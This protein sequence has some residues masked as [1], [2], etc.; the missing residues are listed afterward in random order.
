M[1]NWRTRLITDPRLI[2]CMVMVWV[3][4]MSATYVQAQCVFASP[5]C[6]SSMSNGTSSN[7]NA[8]TW[9][10]NS[11]P[12]CPTGASSSYGGNLKVSMANNTNLTISANF[13]VNGDFNIVNSG[14]NATLTI[15]VGVTLHV[16]GDLGDCTNNNVNFVVNG[17]LIVDGYV[18]GKNGNS[19]AGTGSIT[20][21]GGLYFQG[22]PTCSS[23]G[24]TW[25]V[26]SCVP[27]GAFCTLP[28]QLTSF[29]AAVNA[30]G[31]HVRWITESEDH[32]ELMTLEKSV[33]GIAF[34]ALADFAGHSG[35]PQRRVYGYLD[36][37]AWIGKSY[38]RLKE[39]VLSGAVVYHRIIGVEYTGGRMLDL[40]PVPVN[41]GTLNLRT[42]FQTTTD[43]QVTISNV[44]GA[45]LQSTVLK[46]GEPMKVNVNLDPG[47]YILRYR[48]GDFHSV[49]R[50]VVQ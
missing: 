2:R 44:T 12:A 41:N 25:N 36:E 8:L 19:F 15:P 42:N 38:Y 29:D 31:V 32:V 28:L 18:S 21:T 49:K 11:G 27:A 7:F 17:S 4:A 40:Y 45:V 43:A 39:T 23:C 20:A 10:H 22:T 48:N 35:G 46:A 37:H 34:Q 14:S 9:T 50:I 5:D 6:Q 16:T 47:I 24:I 33:D 30:N 13:T 1:L 3:L 26:G